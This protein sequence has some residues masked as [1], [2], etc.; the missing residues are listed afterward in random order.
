MSIYIVYNKTC[1]AE[2]LIDL[3]Y[4]EI[5]YKYSIPK[6]IVLD[7]GSIFTS[8]V[9]GR[10]LGLY[11]RLISCVCSEVEGVFDQRSDLAGITREEV[12]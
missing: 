7:R 4:E 5:I 2:D 9:G 10:S 1:I 11:I 8:T 6:G 12:W 3:F